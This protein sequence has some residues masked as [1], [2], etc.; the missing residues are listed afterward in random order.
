MEL[1]DQD[2]RGTI[3]NE[4]VKERTK[5]ITELKK[6]KWLWKTNV[7]NSNRDTLWFQ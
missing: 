7:C 1:N 3:F 5:I 4:F 2:P 6:K